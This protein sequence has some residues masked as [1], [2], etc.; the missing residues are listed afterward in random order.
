MSNQTTTKEPLVLVSK[1]AGVTVIPS[2]TLLTR[3]NDELG[4]A[5]KHG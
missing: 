1:Q 3:L 4:T 5:S 2:E